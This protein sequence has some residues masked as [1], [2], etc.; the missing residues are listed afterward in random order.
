MKNSWKCL[1]EDE[2]DLSI[3]RSLSGRDKFQWQSVILNAISLTFIDQRRISM[4][5]DSIE[6]S[7]IL[8]YVCF[9]GR[10]WIEHLQWQKFESG[11]EHLYRVSQKKGNPVCQWDIFIATQVL[12][13]LCASLS[14]AFPLLSLP[15]TWWYLKAWLKINNLN[16]CMSKSI[17]AE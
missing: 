16:S 9:S 6:V 3:S 11:R 12:I 13:K 14:R 7:I 5:I 17:C 10:S 15:N 2:F 4:T 1:N 8:C